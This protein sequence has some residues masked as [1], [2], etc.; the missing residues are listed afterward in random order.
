MLFH[1]SGPQALKDGFKTNITLQST[2]N[3]RYCMY[4]KKSMDI[5]QYRNNCK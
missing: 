1:H 3:H 5:G 4:N 2:D